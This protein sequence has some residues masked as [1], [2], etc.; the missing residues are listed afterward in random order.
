MRIKTKFKKGYW[1]SH[2]RD[3]VNRAACWAVDH[4]GLWD[5]TIASDRLTIVLT[6]FKSAFGDAYQIDDD[7][8][9]RI[10]DRYSDKLTLMT[11]FHEMTHIK[12]Y[13]FDGLDLGTPAMFKG[14]SFRGNYWDAPWEVEAR[15]AEK[16][17]WRKW[18]KY[19]DMTAF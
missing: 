4:Y 1:P 18:K 8:V 14:E 16:K 17:M 11:V 13:E 12:Q 3:L 9:I 6:R 10:S 7:Y 5:L 15:K 2:R 19:L